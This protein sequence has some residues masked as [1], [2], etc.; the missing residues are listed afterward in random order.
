MNA[1]VGFSSLLRA[2]LDGSLKPKDFDYLKVTDENA[3]DL[4]QIVNQAL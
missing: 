1:I 2:R 3:N 4:L